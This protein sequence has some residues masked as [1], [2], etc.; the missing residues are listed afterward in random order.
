MSAPGANADSGERILTTEQMQRAAN[1]RT[2]AS[3]GLLRSYR[4]RGLRRAERELF[5]RHSD[6]LAGRVLE[7]GVGG[8]R[9][10]GH[11]IELGGTVHGMDIAARMVAHCRRTYPGAS[12]SQGDLREASSWG[13]GTWDALVAGWALIDVLTD[14]E[15][16]TFFEDAHR[17]LNPGGLLIFSSHNL[18]CAP[19]LKSPIRSISADTPLSFASQLLRLPRSYRNHRRLMR[20]QRVEPD[21]AILNGAAHDFSLLHY[22]ISRDGQQAQLARHGF[23]LLECI[24][25]DGREVGLGESA[26]GSHEL[27][28]A[29]L[30][31]DTAPQ[32]G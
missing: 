29:A 21:Y 23:E 19:L 14:E 9:L 13:S 20:W 15:R 5:S 18:A 1:A 7:L 4:G 16:A 11:L 2:W 22:Y 8:G 3:G 12:F 30:R 10:T 6:R 31:Q 17:L 28:Y 32:G 26:L 24:D 25:A 27:H